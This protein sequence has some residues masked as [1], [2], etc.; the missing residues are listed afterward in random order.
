LI[1]VFLGLLALGMIVSIPFGH[2]S[3]D[4]DVYYQASRNYLAGSAIYIPHKGIEEFKYLPFFALFFS[5]FAVFSKATAQYLWGILN[6]FLLYLMF[7]YLYKLKLIAFDSFKDF[8]L[9]FCLLALTGR[10]IFSNI[11]IGQANILL[12]FLL[13]LTMYLEM[14]KK[15]LW[16]GITLA[17]SLTIKLFPLIFVA[18]YILRRKFKLAGFTV[19]AAFFLLLLP[20]FYSGFTLNLNYLR[21]WFSLLK[22]SPAPLFYSVKNFSLF[23]FFSWFFIARHEPYFI[24]NYWD[25]PKKLTPQVY[26]SWAISSVVL[27]I[28]FFYDSFLK[29]EKHPELSYLDYACLFV[30]TLLFNPLAYLNALTLLIIPYFFILRA[31]FYGGL[32]RLWAGITGLLTVIGFIVSMAYNKAFFPDRFA[33]Y[34]FLEFRSLM[35]V[36]LLAYFTLLLLKKAYKTRLKIQEG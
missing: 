12:C 23:A 10:Y 21:E 15:D 17:L 31:L 22:S 2:T 5:A 13:A 27:F 11:K 29:K 4:F 30:C 20:A 14:R 28:A 7:Y 8:F 25:I 6:I 35:W 3:G 18:Y 33:F 16:A 26:Y 32:S 36:I 24:F 9:I 1:V 34:K 19:L